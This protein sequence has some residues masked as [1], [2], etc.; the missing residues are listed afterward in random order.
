MIRVLE[1]EVVNQI[2]AGEVLE[3]P[4]N[5]VKELVEN[6]IDANA[7]Q[8]EIDI[9][10]GGR[11]LK[12]SDN[13]HGM[14]PDDL[15]KCLLR[16]ATSKLDR[17]QDLWSLS[18]YGFR[19]EALASAAAV[20]EMT[21]KSRHQAAEQASVL[22]NSY[23]KT[24]AIFEQNG[25]PGTSI[26]VE[27][28]FEN[29]PARLK[30][31]K[32][33]SAETSQILKVIKAFALSHPQVEFKVRVENSLK[34]FYPRSS[35]LLERAKLVLD[36]KELF[37]ANNSYNQQN[38]QV[39]YS[40]PKS[41]SR[42]AQNIWIFVQKRWIQDRALQ[43]AIMDAY[44]NL[45]MHGEYPCCVLF[46]DCDPQT[47]DVNIHPTKSQVKFQDSS[48]AFRNVYHTLRQSLEKAP[49]LQNLFE[50]Q[51][52][53][54]QIQ[55]DSLAS[56]NLSSV[57]NFASGV[58]DAINTYSAQ[59]LQAQFE[60]SNF[61]QALFRKKES[62]T[63]FQ[64]PIK[65]QSEKNDI[66]QIQE[67]EV[68]ANNQNFSNINLDPMWGGLQV[69][70]QL[71]QTYILAQSR[72]AL[73]LIDQHASH[74]RVMFEK[75]MQ[76]WR[77]QK[78]EVQNYLLPMSVDLAPEKVEA[79]LKNKDQLQRM[80]IEIEQSS[81]ESVSIYSAPA[82]IKES[83]LVEAIM[84]MSDDILELGEGFS[85]QKKIADIFATLACHSAIRAGQALSPDEMKELLVSMDL[86]PLSS[87][88]PHGRPV[89][90]QITFTELD[91]DFGR[92]V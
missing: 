11:T 89:Y 50:T 21:L 60:N 81:P 45:L 62:L 19:G 46:L 77:H 86:F 12:I 37:E 74:E 40:S 88:C 70:G 4:A 18:T 3:R 59:H 61:S 71:N 73:F 72:K 82:F 49:W 41:V 26:V 29:V 53:Q 7:T 58:S 75:L 65:N 25:E 14:L 20:S 56:E 47:V 13:G 64:D 78:F 22:K 87:F 31:L 85:I 33:E 10:K 69:L 15:S 51:Q 39:I 17:F 52:S 2:A 79:I 91:R 35:S 6:S 67:S 16:H 28:L 80:G 90:K 1:Q 63:N 43:K 57:S 8:I 54:R 55:N 23:G 84:K 36:Q 27:K 92:I 76:S 9:E 5:L 30:F 66:Q 24:E 44:Q 48:S 32:T 68:Q 42:T 38:V 34:L 83:A